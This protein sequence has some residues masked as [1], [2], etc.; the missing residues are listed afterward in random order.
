MATS[1]LLAAFRAANVARCLEGFRQPLDA[2][3]DDQWIT[4]IGGEIG[5]VCDVVKKLERDAGG[6]AGNRTDRTGLIAALGDEI[7]DAVIYLDLFAAAR[8]PLEYFPS[9]LGILDF[10]DL[11]SWQREAGWHNYEPPLSEQPLPL[12]ARRLLVLCGRLADANF[13]ALAQGKEMLVRLDAL[14]DSVSIDLGG[15]VVAKFNR[16]SDELGVPHRLLVPHG[17]AA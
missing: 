10:H 14:A 7:A 16:K 3:S 1:L 2:W 4:A 6:Y 5:E 17:V 8:G 12:Q 11:R 9:F 13:D 15:A